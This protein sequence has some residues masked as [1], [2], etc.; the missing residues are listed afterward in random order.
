[1]D[2]SSLLQQ[3]DNISVDNQQTY[4]EVTGVLFFNEEEFQ[5]NVNFLN[6]NEATDLYTIKQEIVKEVKKVDTYK[7]LS[8]KVKI[9]IDLEQYNISHKI[10]NLSEA[11][12][13][14]LKFL[15][16]NAKNLFFKKL[17]KEFDIYNLFKKFNMKKTIR[18]KAMRKLLLE[19]NDNDIATRQF[20]ADYLNI[21]LVILT[22]A[23]LN[24]YCKENTFEVY[25]PTII[26]YEYEGNFHTMSDKISNNSIFTSEDH[27]NMRLMK[28]FLNKEIIVGKEKKSVLEAIQKEEPV[29]QKSVKKTE[30]DLI[31]FSK[32]KV[33][34]LRM[35]CGVHSINIKIPKANGKGTKFMNKKQMVEELKAKFNM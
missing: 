4:K 31:D 33:A 30:P 1:M 17:L 5:N 6:D 27:V 9:H 8:Q 35:M 28:Y 19:R 29:K 34:E 22:N 3:L 2:F 24:I 23:D 12:L 20:L 32:Q 16:Y 13:S 7:Q 25:R 26:I 21:N 14:V 18:K 10:G 15:N 11:I